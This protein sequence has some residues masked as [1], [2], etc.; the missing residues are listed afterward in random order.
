MPINHIPAE[1]PRC[2][3]ALRLQRQLLGRRV[4]CRYCGEVFQAG[5]PAPP[6]VEVITLD[7]QAGPARH[8]ATDHGTSN[9]N[10]HARNGP[11]RYPSLSGVGPEPGAGERGARDLDTEL[12]RVRLESEQHL[13]ALHSLRQTIEE[14][15]RD[16]QAARL[17]TQTQRSALQAL[18]TEHEALQSSRDLLQNALAEAD[19]QAA[20][21]QRRHHG[22][23]A[24]LHD[25]HRAHAAAGE[26][27]QRTL[28]AEIDRLR[29]A[30]HAATAE[31]EAPASRPTAKLPVLCRDLERWS[32]TL[33]VIDARPSNP[34][35]PPSLDDLATAERQVLMLRRLLRIVPGPGKG[36]HSLFDPRRFQLIQSR[37]KEAGLLADRFLSQVERSKNQKDL[38]WHLMVAQRSAEVNRRRR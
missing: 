30:L 37:L 21:T 5:G 10:G 23:L 9:G 17:E 8:L 31:T 24:A 38:L 35:L 36:Y 19:R 6:A 15:D 12:A 4:A 29:A 20:D 2:R 16:L 1:C 28:L 26:E 33:V 27:A 18:Q 13:K 3:Q 25:A 34:T 11:G 14:R 7:D 32:T 22:D